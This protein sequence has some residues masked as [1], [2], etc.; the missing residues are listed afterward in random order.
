MAVGTAGVP[1]NPAS[2]VPCYP[3]R[4][5]RLCSETGDEMGALNTREE[6]ERE[7][8]ALR[9]SISPLSAAS[10][11]ISECPDLETVLHYALEPLCQRAHQSPSN[12]ALGG[13]GGGVV[14][15]NS[16]QRLGYSHGWFTLMTTTT[17]LS[18][19]AEP[20]PVWLG[21]FPE[22]PH[23]TRNDTE[24]PR[25]KRQ[26]E[27]RFRL[28]CPPLVRRNGAQYERGAGGGFLRWAILSHSC[29]PSPSTTS[30]TMA[31]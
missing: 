29:G 24:F 13:A 20:S 5:C 2:G 19:R 9:A 12:S 30:P 11:R 31:P 16:L 15:V 17:L 10:L 22:T 27:A 26:S 21:D 7:I 28:A 23:W 3:G 25:L 4:R 14:W 8:E 18:Q 1:R 6:R